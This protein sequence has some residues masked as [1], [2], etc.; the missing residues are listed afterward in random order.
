MD[1]IYMFNLDL[2]KAE[3]LTATADSWGT[4]NGGQHKV[5][6]QCKEPLCSEFSAVIT[7]KETDALVSR[8]S[9]RYSEVPG[10]SAGL[11]KF[12]PVV[13]LMN[14]LGS[15]DLNATNTQFVVSQQIAVSIVD[16]NEI[17]H[18]EFAAIKV[19]D[20]SEARSSIIM[21]LTKKATVASA[22]VGSASD[23]F[24]FLAAMTNSSDGFDIRTSA[25]KMSDDS[26]KFADAVLGALFN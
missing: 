1:D 12:K 14:E 21:T 7:E 18:P 16:S 20:I 3:N 10:D 15:L 13:D 25:L 26:I 23:Y 19:S 2:S 9:G 17:A 6:L 5:T 4:Y 24:G 8:L 22:K 11:L